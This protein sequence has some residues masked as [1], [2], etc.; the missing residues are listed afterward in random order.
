MILSLIIFGSLGW[1]LVLIFLFSI[2][3][4]GKQKDDF[5]VIH[6]SALFDGRVAKLFKY[7]IIEGIPVV[8]QGDL[9]IISQKIESGE[10]IEGGREALLVIEE[11]SARVFEG[12]FIDVCK[13]FKSTAVIA[14]DSKN[15]LELKG[16]KCI[17]IKSLD[18]LGKG[19]IFMGDKIHVRDVKYGYS[20][21]SGILDDGTIV[22]IEGKLPRKKTLT[23]DCYVEAIVE[24]DTFRKIW[25]RCKE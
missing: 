17:Y 19:K 9:D 10:G 7:G 2:W 21:A 23:L 18:N 20:R 11:L 22:E 8:S 15:E 1:V 4:K 12:N 3:N 13:R 6:I 24:G 5:K 25:G 14:G 16:I